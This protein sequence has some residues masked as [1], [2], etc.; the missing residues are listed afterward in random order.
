M[1]VKPLKYGCPETFALIPQEGVQVCK[2][3]GYPTSNC[4][5]DATL[6]PDGTF[7]LSLGSEA[8]EG[9]Y[10][11]LNRYNE[12]E[13]KVETCFYTKDYILPQKRSFPGSKLHSNIDFLPDGRIICCNHTTDKPPHHPE[14]LP[15]AYHS[16]PWESFAGSSIFIYDPKTGFVDSC[17]IPAPKE[18]LYGGVYSEKTNSYYTV[19]FFKGHI[20]KY[21]LTTREATDL[22]KGIETCSHRLHVGPDKNIYYTSPAGWL[23][24]INTDNDKLEWTGI[25]LPKHQTPD[26]AERWIPRYLTSYFNL[27]NERMLVLAGYANQMYEYNIRTNEIK[28]YGQLISCGELFEGYGNVYYNFSGDLDKDGVLWYSVS[29]RLDPPENDRNRTHPT[30]AYLLRW[31]WQH[32]GQQE[33]LGVIGCPDQAF[34]LLSDLRIDRER[35]ILFAAASA[36]QGSTPPIIRIDL[37]AQRRN[38]NTQGPAHTDKRYL[39][40]PIDPTTVK[41]GGYEG[42]S[43]LNNHEAFNTQKVY[44]ARIWTELK[45]DQEN[46]HVRGLYWVNNK[47]VRGICGADEPKYGFEIVDKA[48]VS[49]TLLSEMDTALREEYLTKSIPTIPPVAD[50]I[51]LPHVAGR[52]YLAAPS[53]SAAWHDGRT[54]YGTK[55]GM[56][57]LVG[58]KNVFS[59]GLTSSSGPVRAICT[60]AD[61]TIAWGTCG[62]DLDLCGIFRYDDQCGLQTLGLLYWRAKGLNHLVSPDT[63][64]CIAASPD[65]CMLAMGSGDRMGTVFLADISS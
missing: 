23:N 7:Y 65:D 51:K 29:P 34:W 19:G 16:H 13:N 45:D 36:N 14:W 26:V 30:V 64:T 56:L 24:R 41:S 58:E 31:D 2:P 11:Y 39:P 18:T 61:R 60:N 28:E 59:L 20:V 35:D 22:G 25:R 49:V 47:T 38:A 46:S 8:G 17:G 4:C 43:A 50:S 40:T 48:V 42:A 9:N 15:Y 27:D 57:A 6:S 54:I 12:E 55:D 37:A 1:F 62:D 32:G 3:E 21:D 5:W 44:Q 63:L 53:A 33:L 52:Q 10:A